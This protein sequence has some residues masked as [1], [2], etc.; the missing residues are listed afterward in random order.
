MSNVHEFY[1]SATIEAE[2]GNWVILLDSETPLTES[3]H[4]AFAE[5]MSRSPA[6]REEMKQLAQFW[7]K[8]NVLT[9][10]AIPTQLATQRPKRANL[11]WGLTSPTAIAASVLAITLSLGLWFQLDSQNQLATGL[12]ATAVGQQKSIE[13]A[14]GSQVQLNTNSQIRVDYSNANRDIWLLQG[15]AHFVVAKNPKRPFRVAAG[16][17]RV[18]AIGTAFAVYL[19]G[20]DL[21][22]TVTEGRVE[23]QALGPNYIADSST[24]ANGG[25]TNSTLTNSTLTNSTV[26]NSTLTN[27]R[28]TPAITQKTLGQLDA[29]QGVTIKNMLNHSSLAQADIEQADP[30]E[31]ARRLDWRSGFIVFNGDPLNE[32]VAEISRYTLMKIELTDPAMHNIK[33]GGQFRV[34][35]MDAM[36]ESLENNFGIRVKRV[37]YNY[38]QLS[39]AEE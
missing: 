17:G 5:W 1:D 35:E 10:L 19:N 21:D 16:S 37:A 33:I 12:Y 29:G 34:G 11:F 26:T 24:S 3:Q 15:E 13:L 9:D 4:K 6:H 23:L 38:I 25:P 8:M 20:V 14:D 7:G 2:A 39:L 22:I 30:Q 36:L 27:R 28:A 31:M 32:V 18:E